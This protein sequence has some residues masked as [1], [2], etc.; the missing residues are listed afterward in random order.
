MNQKINDEDPQADR[1]G[2]QLL[3]GDLPAG[4]AQNHPPILLETC[5]GIQDR[6]DLRLVASV[7]EG[8]SWVLEEFIYIRFNC[9]K[10]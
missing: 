10:F 6:E 9:F 8:N 1:P 5:Q 7:V 3:P 4:G 2:R